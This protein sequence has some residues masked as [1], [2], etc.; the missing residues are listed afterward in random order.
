M[1][2]TA[3]RR[4][5]TV[6]LVALLLATFLTAMEATVVSTA[7]PTII[8]E[9]HGLDLYAWVF[10][11]YLLTSTATVPLYGRLA[12]MVGRKPVFLAGIGIF[13]AGSALSG[14]SQSMPELI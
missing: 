2:Q 4:N 8:G 10:S 7:M 1:E 12:D 5:R 9:L 6:I 11:A 13:L 3:S 14:L